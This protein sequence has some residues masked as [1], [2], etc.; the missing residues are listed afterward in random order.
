MLGPIIIKQVVKLAKGTARF[1]A[2]AND[3]IA[4]FELGCPPKGELERIIQQKN[5]ITTALTQVSGVIDTITK[6]K[7]NNV[8]S[9][10]NRFTKY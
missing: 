4:K 1:D 9:R 10:P 5:T 8:Y 2:I 6:K 7:I 3:I